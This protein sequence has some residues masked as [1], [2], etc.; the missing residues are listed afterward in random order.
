MDL[1]PA[2]P[3]WLSPQ[4]A[5]AASVSSGGRSYFLNMGCM[6]GNSSGSLKISATFQKHEGKI[7]ARALKAEDTGRSTLSFPSSS[8]R[9][10]GK[11][12]E[13][14][15]EERTTRH[16]NRQ[17]FTGQRLIIPLATVLP[18]LL[19]HLYP[20]TPPVLVPRGV[21]APVVRMLPLVC[22]P[23]HD[24]RHD[25]VARLVRA[26]RHPA[27]VHLGQRRRRVHAGPEGRL[28]QSCQMFVGPSK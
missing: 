8:K 23:A 13:E 7:F 22:V 27:R 2:A 5:A 14:E 19:P 17:I 25:S 12:E 10:P 11:H 16:Y 26:R 20:R 4:S 21:L 1:V 28:L 15:E 18:P 24:A 6:H 9:D 3:T